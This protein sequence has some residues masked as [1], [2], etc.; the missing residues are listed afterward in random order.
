MRTIYDTKRKGERKIKG[1]CYPPRLRR[2]VE[3]VLVFLLSFLRKRKRGGGG[4]WLVG[5]GKENNQWTRA[6]F[7][8]F[9]IFLGG[10][11]LV[12]I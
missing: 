3:G 1:I 9:F 8:I 2:V 6:Y 10:F 4:G 11:L 5:L 12:L 7:K